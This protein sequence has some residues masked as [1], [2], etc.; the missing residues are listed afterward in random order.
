MRVRVLQGAGTA[1]VEPLIYGLVGNALEPARDVGFGPADFQ[2]KGAWL[3]TE[4]VGL[5]DPKDFGQE[6][7]FNWGRQLDEISTVLARCE[8]LL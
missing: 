1:L 6:S 7:G 2:S 5:P 3:G 4:I 8:R